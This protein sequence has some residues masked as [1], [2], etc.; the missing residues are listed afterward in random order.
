MG[1]TLYLASVQ[2]STGPAIAG[3]TARAAKAT[4]ALGSAAAG[5][6]TTTA[7][8]RG[9]LQS[10]S[11]IEVAHH[12]RFMPGGRPAARTVR[13]RQLHA[14]FARASLRL[15][16]AGCAAAH[17]I[18]PP[19]TC[20]TSVVAASQPPGGAA[21]CWAW[22]GAHAPV[23]GHRMAVRRAAPAGLPSPR[24][25]PPSGGHW[26][27]TTRYYQFRPALGGHWEPDRAHSAGEFKRP[28]STA[29]PAS[30]A[31]GAQRPPRDWGNAGKDSFQA[32][33]SE[34]Q[35]PCCR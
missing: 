14:L 31:C 6:T 20:V 24:P 16:R 5:L 10:I 3:V 13:A 2:T 17:D 1:L 18:R 27:V 29:G 33:P 28:T 30:G 11:I 4:S 8:L 21:R 9:R 15:G 25:P 35:R 19:G 7:A 22:R 26:P 32:S 12:P 23:F 34:A